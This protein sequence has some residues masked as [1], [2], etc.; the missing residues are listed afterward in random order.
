MIHESDEEPIEVDPF[1]AP[2]KLL[3]T[4]PSWP[5]RLGISQRHLYAQLECGRI[6]ISVLRFGK[7][8]RFSTR[9]SANIWHVT[10]QTA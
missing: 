7:S 1:P 9:G 6:G 5:H 10:H 8:I 2:E 4:A 3:F